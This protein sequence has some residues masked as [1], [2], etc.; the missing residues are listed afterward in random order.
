[1]TVQGL[2]EEPEEIINIAAKAKLLKMETSL[3]SVAL[4]SSSSIDIEPSG[5]AFGLRLSDNKAPM[6]LFST[7]KLREA[8]SFQGAKTVVDEALEDYEQNEN[9]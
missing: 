2:P 3:G 5:T 1:M 6:L 9:S 8:S 7:K 4:S